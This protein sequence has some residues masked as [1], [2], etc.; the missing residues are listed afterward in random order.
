MNEVITR[1]SL[2]MQRLKEISFTVFNKCR[3]I[4]Y[5]TSGVDNSIGSPRSDLHLNPFSNA[6]DMVG[7]PSRSCMTSS[8][9]ERRGEHNSGSEEEKLNPD[10]KQLFEPLFILSRV[11]I[12]PLLDPGVLRFWTLCCTCFVLFLEILELQK[13]LLDHV[14]TIQPP[15]FQPTSENSSNSRSPDLQSST[16][17]LLIQSFSPT[18]QCF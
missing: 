3:R 9:N 10:I 6:M 2:P 5:S 17:A 4:H 18:I 8:L 12:L 7:R 11:C 14:H 15:I 13:F 1:S 16:Y